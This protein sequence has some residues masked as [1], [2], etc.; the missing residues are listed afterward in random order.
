M[1]PSFSE[2]RPATQGATAAS[3]ASVSIVIPV[4]NQ[5]PVT[6]ACLASLTRHT[7]AGIS[8]I[9][10]VDDASTE[11]YA[12]ALAGSWPQVEVLR[13]A[14]NLGFAASCNRGAAAASGAYLLFLNNDT[15]A[16]PGWL[17]PL[18]SLLE[19]R[20]EVGI[21]VPKLIHPDRTIQ[22]CGKVW[23]ELDGEFAQPTHIYFREPADSAKV[24]QSREYAMVTGA[25]LLVRREEFLTLG[26][27][28]EGFENGWEDDD[29]CY[30]YSSAGKKIWYCAES[31]LIHFESVT[32]GADYRLAEC[33]FNRRLAA[34]NGQSSPVISSEAEA[35]LAPYFEMPYQELVT[36][37]EGKLF[38]VRDRFFRNKARFFAK[39]GHL[40]RRDD[41]RYFGL[42]GATVQEDAAELPLPPL[43]SIVILTFNQLDF[44][45]QTVESIRRHTPEP[46]EIIFVDNG[47]Q[48]GT[49][50]WLELQA[51]ENRNYRLIANRSNLG[52]AAGCNQGMRAAHGEFILLL[53]NDVMVTP[54]WLSGMLACFDSLTRVG[55]VGPVTNNISG[56]QKLEE[57]HYASSPELDT[58]A[59]AHRERFSGCR[60]PSRRIVG[61][62]ML[63][64]RELVDLIGL[65]D[66]EF[67]SGNFEDDDFALRAALEGFQN[68]IAYDVF[69]HH[70]GSASFS[71]NRI[72]YAGAMARNRKIF[73]RK[74]SAPVTDPSLGRK[75]QRLRAT[76]KAELL[77]QRGESERAVETI[78]QEGIK[79]IPE[80]RDFYLLVAEHFLAEGRQSD[81]LET[82]NV[83]PAH[84]R[85]A[86]W[87]R[88][89]GRALAASGLPEQAETHLNLEGTPAAARAA[90]LGLSGLIA[91]AS[92]EQRK[93][94]QHFNDA[95]QT[96]PF[97]AEAYLQLAGMASGAGSLADACT[98]AERSFILAPT[99]AKSASC[100]HGLLHKLGRQEQGLALFRTMA[101]LYPENRMLAL[102]LVDLLLALGKNPE[103]LTVIEEFLCS[104]P[105]DDGFLDACLAVRAKVGPLEVKA[106]TEAFPQTVSLCLI[107]KNEAANLPRCLKSLKPLVH[108]IILVDSGSQDRTR[109]IGRIFGA[110]IFDFSWTGS[111]SDARNASLEKARGA[112]ILVMDADEVISMLDYPGF[113]ET[114]ALHAQSPAVF[115]ITTR[116]YMNQVDIEK[117]VQNEG[118]Y[119]EELGAGWTPSGKIRL[120]PNF[121]G[122]RFERAIHEMVDNSVLALKLQVL[123]SP[124]VVHH[125]G[126]LDNGRQSEKQ[127]FYY[128]L[129]V[130]KLA[131][132]PDDPIAICELAIQ[133]A[134]V[135]HYRE[136]I[137]LWERALGYDP[138]SPLAFFNLG[139]CY[140]TVGDFLLSRNASLKAMQLQA[141]YRE[142]IANYALA[143]LCL[144]NIRAAQ[145]AVETEL[146]RDRNYPVLEII[147]GICYCCAG[148]PDA[149][150]RRFGELK[151]RSVEFSGFIQLVLERLSTAG[152]T[153]FTSE[154]LKVAKNCGFVNLENAETC[155]Q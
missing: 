128:Q 92:D 142:A 22:H 93:A 114:L 49:L 25:C 40:V 132:N 109:D 84:L 67:G 69:I 21:V 134:A 41:L 144:G 50:D 97:C 13:N 58:F 42:D 80:E 153:C 51:R 37:L 45:K 121:L 91:L 20:P 82:L 30:A 150:S 18:L 140:L 131:D 47:S 94:A 32:L 152:Q 102:Y 108:E 60:V 17:P 71:G 79:F 117:W 62:C 136:A 39:W 87:G 147:L 145:Q 98:L 24:N 127:E 28:D 11:S 101:G 72:D 33:A 81:A 34:R 139:S 27:F 99:L 151:A 90:A 113:Q 31:T 68:L 64:R 115:S 16:L 12:E 76:E 129:G 75:I 149:G 124:V 29:L 10:V 36:L 35:L 89:S 57:A 44:T 6:L 14:K 138:R 143:E 95:L 148:H 130:T 70:H 55:I 19:S 135:Q 73:N 8:E 126:Y 125:Y 7:P 5:L 120:F 77:W 104:F 26:P 116:N 103:A 59:V 78:L 88:L 100:Y 48:D 86:H 43:T 137:L 146:D 96:D 56:P 3:R 155:Q 105:C 119:P 61:F 38:K 111:F 118:L 54:G 112:W 9:I 23:G 63:F 15:E 2:R 74:W 83:L 141:N 1:I 110:R 52:F 66:E 123:E 65:L 85:D 46:H 53:N 106:G 154:L 4:L 122:I 107:T 133:A